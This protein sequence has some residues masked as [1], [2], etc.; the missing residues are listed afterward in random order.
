MR[1]TAMPTHAGQ[2]RTRNFLSAAFSCVVILA[3]CA[4]G[5]P[6][7]PGPGTAQPAPADAAAA[8]QPPNPERNPYFRAVHVH[9]S[10]SFD[11]YINGTKTTPQD[12]YDWAQGKEITN[13]GVGGKIRIQTPLDFYM[14]SDH[15]EFMGAMS[16]MSNPD[17][18]IA[19]SKLGKG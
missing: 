6:A 12:A 7:A 13:S 11:A 8:R 18:A 4:K 17:S 5:P 2:F 9:T 3:G 19:K 15:A 10:Y 14:V 16:Q 1:T